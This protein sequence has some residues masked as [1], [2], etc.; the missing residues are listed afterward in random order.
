MYTTKDEPLARA[1]SL[2]G[3]VGAERCYRD[4]VL[5]PQLSSRRHSL[6][7]FRVSSTRAGRPAP[8]DALPGMDILRGVY[9][10]A[11]VQ[12]FYLFLKYF[13][14]HKTINK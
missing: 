6:Q 5:G 1:M 3:R 14:L 2:M 8:E 10:L 7:E 12:L 11:Q 13:Y 4:R 9:T